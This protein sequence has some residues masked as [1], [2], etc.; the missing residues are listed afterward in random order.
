M[1]SRSGHH[2]SLASSVNA[3]INSEVDFPSADIPVSKKPPLSV[4]AGRVSSKL[5]E[6]DFSG[7]AIRL[8]SSYDTIAENGESVFN[9]L[10]EC[11]PCPPSNCTM[12]SCESVS[13]ACISV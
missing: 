5:E 13:S 1:P 7:G 8:A 9:A 6:G 2:R 11:H 4:L 10:C 3:Q 12:P